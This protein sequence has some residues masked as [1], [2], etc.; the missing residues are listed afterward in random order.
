[1]H[2]KIS[3]YSDLLPFVVTQLYGVPLVISLA[4]CLSYKPKFAFECEPFHLSST[5]V[6]KLFL[7]PSSV[8]ILNLHPA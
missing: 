5:K 3:I 6:S 2:L 7:H 1:M 4:S 8:C